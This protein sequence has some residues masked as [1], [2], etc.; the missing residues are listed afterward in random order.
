M[1]APVQMPARQFD[2]VPANPAPGGLFTAATVENVDE[3]TR[4]EG[5]VEVTP[6]NEGGH[7]FWEPS[8]PDPD[9]TASSGERVGRTRSPS[10]IVW[11]QDDCG[12]LGNSKEEALARASQIL[13]LTE[14]IDTEEHTAARLLVSAGTPATAPTGADVFA[15]AVGNLEQALGVTGVNGIIHA[16]RGLA[17]IA[18]R[19]GLIVQGAGGKLMTPL[20]NTWAFGG[21][22]E[23]LGDNLV[24]TGPVTVRKG[25]VSTFES[26]AHRHNDRMAIAE[27]L[28]NV[29][30]ELTTVAQAIA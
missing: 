14:V 5:G 26:V 4:M 1:T 2:A 17:A 20:G 6:V 15:T 13:R 7:G 30:W 22:Y 28:I 24:A 18:A 8:C 16:R 21:G 12:L 10:L 27:R 3:P 29:S 25:P 23:S 9:N 11:A 19:Y